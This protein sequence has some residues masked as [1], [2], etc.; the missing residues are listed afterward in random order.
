MKIKFP[1]LSL[2]PPPRQTEGEAISIL[3][4]Q[5]GRDPEFYG[6]VRSLEAYKKLLESDAT[7]I[8]NV[9]SDLWRYLESPLTPAD[10]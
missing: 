9:E 6:F 5:L 4:E 2:Y 7:L 1:N 3:S 8:L 10:R